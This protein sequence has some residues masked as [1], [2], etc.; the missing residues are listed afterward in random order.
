[1]LHSIGSRLST[2]G[3]KSVL[4]VGGYDEDGWGQWL[5]LV[6]QGGRVPSVHVRKSESYP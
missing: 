5:V 6:P 2:A 1:M 4:C 3:R